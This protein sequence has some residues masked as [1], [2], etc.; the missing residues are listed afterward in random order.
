MRRVK[1]SAHRRAVRPLG[2][3]GGLAEIAAIRKTALARHVV[4]VEVGVV[5]LAVGLI[6]LAYSARKPNSVALRYLASVVEMLQETVF[7][8]KH[9]VRV[10]FAA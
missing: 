3:H 5:A 8:Y 10:V 6:R 2:Y 1:I 4:Y 7:V 9:G